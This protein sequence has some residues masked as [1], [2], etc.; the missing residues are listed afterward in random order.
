MNRGTASEVKWLAVL[1]SHKSVHD[2]IL[3]FLFNMCSGIDE[4]LERSS[5]SVKADNGLFKD[6]EGSSESNLLV[7]RALVGALLTSGL[8]WTER[9]RAQTLMFQLGPRDNTGSFNEELIK[10]YK[11]EQVRIVLTLINRCCYMRP[12][13]VLVWITSEEDLI[14]CTRVSRGLR[15]LLAGLLGKF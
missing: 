4:I 9:G 8:V 15:N 11:D 1:E 6:S 13:S 5:S 3:S 7:Y 14:I 10:F 12:A 2:S